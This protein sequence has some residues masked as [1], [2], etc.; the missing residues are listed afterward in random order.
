VDKLE[1]A[2][3][4]IQSKIESEGGSLVIKMKVRRAS[5]DALSISLT[6]YDQPKAVSETEE[7]DL[8]QLMAKAGAENT[9]VAGDDDE[10]EAVGF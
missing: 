8:A 5:V 3:T 7:Q 2:I 1:K 4:A 10:E 6:C 9:E